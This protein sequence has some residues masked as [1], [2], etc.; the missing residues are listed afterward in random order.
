MSHR[1]LADPGAMVYKGRVYLYLSND[2]DNKGTTQYLMK[3]IVCVSSSDMKNWTDHGIVFR[4]PDDASW[5][6]YSWAP[7][8]LVR[9]DKFYLYFGNNASGVGVATSSSP[10]GGFKDPIKKYLVNSSTPGAKGTDGGWLFDPGAFID[11]DGK[12]YLSFGGNGATNGRIIQLGSDLTSVTGS[13]VGGLTTS[14][15]NTWFEASYLFKRKSIYYVA[16]S[17]NGSNGQRMDYFMSSNPMSGWTYA[18]VLADQPPVNGNNNHTAEFE[19]NGRWY[20]AYHNRS[21]AKAAGIDPTCSRNLGME[22]LDFQDDG[23]IVRITSAKY[24]TDGVPQVGTLDPYVRVE[25]E[26]MNAQKGIETEACSAGGMNVTDI[27]SGDWVRVRGVNFGTPGAKTF[28]AQIAAASAGGVIEL[29]SGSETGTLLGSCSVPATGGSTT[30]KTVTCDVTGATGVVSDLYLKF[31]GGNF[32]FDYWQFTGSGSGGS[33]GASSTGGASSVG[34][35]SANGGTSAT[36]GVSGVVAS[37]GTTSSQSGSGSNPTLGGTSASGGA[38]STNGGVVATTVSAQATG[39]TSAITGAAT[40]TA[41]AVGGSGSTESTEV[42]G[43]GESDDSGCGCYVAGR[44]SRPTSLAV[45]ALLALV[46]VRI[47]RRRVSA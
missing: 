12:A 20:H 42:G 15:N 39:G 24:T 40:S 30:W 45:V 13:A 16:Y 7:V 25:A 29:R 18:G 6:N 10:T 26:T 9:D 27:S 22:V 34:G 11:D 36:G 46:G 19:F 14:S 2:D 23:K 32:K 47:S 28:T 41:S 35:A 1:Y 38:P 21:V 33:G 44:S 3:S 17:T 8:P 31:T 5:A 43:D 4:V 37:G